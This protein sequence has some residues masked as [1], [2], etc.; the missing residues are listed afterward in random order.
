M[1]PF[2]YLILSTYMPDMAFQFS[3]C[4]GHL[5]PVEQSSCVFWG[6]FCLFVLL[7]ALIFISFFLIFLFSSFFRVKSMSSFQ[8]IQLSNSES[9]LV[10]SIF[11]FIIS[12]FIRTTL[13]MVVIH[14][15]IDS[16]FNDSFYR[17]AC[18][19][20]DILVLFI[21]NNES[22]VSRGNDSLLIR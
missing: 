20:F 11:H 19:W 7:I 22:V 1:L 16:L 3:S 14:L 13:Q 9:N 17:Q 12:F 15:S 21:L 8:F 5:K 6:V 2:Q 4:C 18:I 10:K